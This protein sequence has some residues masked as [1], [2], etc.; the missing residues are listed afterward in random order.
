MEHRVQCRDGR[1]I[2]VLSRAGIVERDGSGNAL[3]L[4][5]TVVDITERKVAEQRLHYLATRDALTDLTN[6]ALFGDSLQEA[7]DEAARWKDR[8]AVI[9]LGLD[10]FTAIND[11]LGQQ[12][13]DQVLKT[14]ATRLRDLASAEMSVAR[15]GGDEFLV[16]VPGVHTPERIDRIAE[17]IRKVV[18]QPIS[19]G[20]QEL[21]VTASVGVAIFPD[22][23]D[24]AG[25]LIRNADIALHSAKAGGRN[26]VQYFAQRMNVAAASRLEVEGAIRRGLE[27]DQFVV[28]YQPQI[29]LATGMTI[30][31][32]ALARWQ[33]PKRGLVLPKDFIPIADV[34]GLLVPLGE[35]IL[36]TACRDAA[37]LQQHAPCRVSVNAAASQ[38]RHAGFVKAVEDALASSQLDP[39]LLELEIT[40][41]SLIE[42]GA[43]DIAMVLK[44]ISD[45][46]VQIA[47]DDFGVGY[48]SLAYLR[49]LPID[50]LKIDR[51]FVTDL[52]G[53]PDAGA[54]VGAIIVLSHKLGLKVVAEGVE[55][56]A[57]VDYLR[58]RGC[59]QAQGYLFGQPQPYEV[60]SASVGSAKARGLILA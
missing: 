30:G 28:Y 55:T 54:I 17:A 41:D 47:V 39:R 57:Q 32:E 58:D 23:A 33:H 59:D 53:D 52:P 24:S 50:T 21:V 51:S 22:D 14:V 35:R 56:Q 10:R 12:A 1:W 9:S 26:I 6:R 46:G 29:D 48:S 34:T 42:H 11:S 27:R 43:N 44:A 3:R 15:P 25:L 40:E 38:L 45:L 5:G 18:A 8:V 4:A 36:A 60:V 13:G 31:Y 20:K 7:L 19:V 37:H 2:W 49:R 16:L